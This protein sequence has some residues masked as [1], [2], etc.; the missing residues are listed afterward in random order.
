LTAGDRGI[1]AAKQVTPRQAVAVPPSADLCALYISRLT[2]GDLD[3]QGGRFALGPRI[4]RKDCVMTVAVFRRP[5]LP[6]GRG[7]S[8]VRRGLESPLALASGVF[9]ASLAWTLIVRLPLF[10]ADS[11]DD[12]SFV[13]IAHLWLQGVLPLCRRL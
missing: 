2:S 1:G 8:F 9:V 5:P 11:A 7:D 4:A 12:A 10:R 3:R 13:E 6:T